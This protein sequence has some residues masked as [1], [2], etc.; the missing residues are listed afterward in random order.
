VFTRDSEFTMSAGA[1]E[2]PSSL[3]N[4]IAPSS[5]LYSR[6]AFASDIVENV[7]K[8]EQYREFT[9]FASTEN[10]KVQDSRVAA[11]TSCFL[12]SNIAG[13][14][15]HDTRAMADDA[16]VFRDVVPTYSSLLP[17][18]GV[19]RTL[20]S[21]C[22]FPNIIIPPISTNILTNRGRTE[23]NNSKREGTFNGAESGILLS[24][25]N[26]SST[27]TITSGSIISTPAGSTFS[28]S[29]RGYTSATEPSTTGSTASTTSTITNSIRAKNNSINNQFSNQSTS[30]TSPAFSRMKF[31][32]GHQPNVNYP[33][34]SLLK[35]PC[36]SN[37]AVG[38]NLQSSAA[39]VNQSIENSDGANVDR[40][41][42]ALLSALCD[43]RERKGLLRLE[44]VLIDF[45]NE[46]TTG[47]IEVGGPNNSIV[48]G[49][50]TGG[51]LSAG[52]SA[53]GGGG[54]GGGGDD[55]RGRQT[56]F[57][58]LCLH[59]LADRFN[60]VRENATSS[61]SASPFFP[62]QTSATA[63]VEEQN[64]PSANCMSPSSAVVPG[65]IRLVKVKSSRIPPHLLIDLDVSNY[66]YS[67]GPVGGGPLYFN[68]PSDSG[69]NQR[70]FDSSMRE[71]E[72]AGSSEGV[73]ALTDSVSNASLNRS[74][75]VVVA[76]RRP[77][78]KQGKKMMIMKRGSGGNNRGNRNKDI[79]GNGS[80]DSK[81][82]HMQSGIYGKGLKGRNI[83]DKE[84]IYAEARARIFNDLETKAMEERIQ[85]N[86]PETADQTQVLEDYVSPP[87]AARGVSYP[88]SRS[89]SPAAS[90]VKVDLGG[91]KRGIQGF[92]DSDADRSAG[93]NFETSLHEA[94]SDTHLPFNSRGRTKELFVQQTVGNTP[95]SLSTTAV[96]SDTN[97]VASKVTWRNRRQEENDPD[98][99][100]GVARSAVG[101]GTAGAVM[102][103]LHYSG[104]PIAHGNAVF[105]GGSNSLSAAPPSSYPAH[106]G[107]HDTSYGVM[108]QSHQSSAPLSTKNGGT[109]YHP[110]QQ[111]QLYYGTQSPASHPH[112]N[113]NTSSVGQHNPYVI[114]QQHAAAAYYAQHQQQNTGS[115][116]TYFS[117]AQDHQGRQQ[118]Q[119]RISPEPSQTSY[120]APNT[121][122]PS[123]VHQQYGI[124]YGGSNSGTGTGRRSDS[125]IYSMDEFPA[126]G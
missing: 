16:V 107:M 97:G 20:N 84:K 80:K 30:G 19:V 76:C 74:G 109:H 50:Q 87:S 126:L 100:R 104:G 39:N 21:D 79:N 66:N 57:Q 93:I 13:N 72:Q 91:F 62:Q 55:S 114:S 54:N 14:I 36:S 89:P 116:T 29:S 8:A 75:D 90:H 119:H 44:Q 37:D 92:V 82:M 3:A 101:T 98:F 60:I 17:V 83:S 24:T 51:R 120:T 7:E 47:Y 122:H 94:E 61:W 27:T 9:S 86:P 58:R 22:D 53:L 56:S 23:F 10:K 96:A 64:S 102:S 65:L 59:R 4:P 5:T 71:G 105:V 43:Q 33:S 95:C 73:K 6:H 117:Q 111:H 11:S 85:N 26:P 108:Q 32:A 18:P 46:R 2:R 121:S 78:Q 113:S 77:A 63:V 106:G 70:N 40:I 52:A 67:D 124:F 118:Y 112:Y 123:Q 38:S 15:E 1:D 25:H 31:A 41:D 88:S 42:S 99:R 34:S 115:T 28:T 48:T 35:Q 103:H 81:N 49:G 69:G 110:Q 68:S 45:M 12:T 125:A